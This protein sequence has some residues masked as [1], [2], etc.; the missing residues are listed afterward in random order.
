MP[1]TYA[2]LEQLDAATL[3]LVADRGALKEL[4]PLNTRGKYHSRSM[5][6]RFPI[7]GSQLK[8]EK[9][10]ES[11]LAAKKKLLLDGDVRDAA[12][13]AVTPNGGS[14]V[15]KQL[16]RSSYSKLDYYVGMMTKDLERE[17]EHVLN[18]RA[19]RQLRLIDVQHQQGLDHFWTLVKTGS[20][21]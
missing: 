2:D 16:F 8:L 11:F 14:L 10:H 20:S 18:D 9:E 17:Q 1:G 4:A 5:R 6:D 12:R 15:A 7:A 19:N 3:Q 13:H 21:R